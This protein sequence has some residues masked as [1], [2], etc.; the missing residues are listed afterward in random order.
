M[1]HRRSKDH[2]RNTEERLIKRRKSCTYLRIATPA[3]YISIS[4]VKKTIAIPKG[5]DNVEEIIWG[6]WAKKV[7]RRERE[8]CIHELQHQYYTFP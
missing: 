3:L 1:W 8:S 2:K 6:T 7:K 5:Y 4:K